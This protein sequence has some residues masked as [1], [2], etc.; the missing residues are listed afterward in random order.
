MAILSYAQM[1]AVWLNVA[2]GTQ[3]GT[4]A[5][6]SLMAAIAM[7]ESSGNANATNPYDNG[8]TQTS[9]GLWQISLGNH[10]APS[11]NWND[12]V[13][14]AQL[15]L[16]KLENPSGLDNWGTYTSGA[17]KTYLNGATTP[18][19]AGISGGSTVDAAYL[20]SASATASNCLWSIPSLG[21]VIGNTGG[22]IVGGI[23]GGITGNPSAGVS[24]LAG[25]GGYCIFSRS[26]ARGLVGAGM[27]IAGI[28]GMLSGSYMLIGLN[29]MKLAAP[30]AALAGPEGAAA[31][32]AVGTAESYTGARRRSRP[33]Q[34]AAT[35]NR[36]AASGREPA[37]QGRRRREQD[38][39]A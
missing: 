38:Q 15:A 14:N 39:A 4:N 5:Y 33:T 22:G 6:A 26:E 31:A 9:W 17:Y 29:A 13:V 3:Y 10:D 34:K 1:K 30:V 37:Y 28:A 25:G 11:P 7:A 20:T 19:G 35:E 36:R 27:L 32:G 2:Q 18:D 21:S 16:A 8:G 23:I 12:P 24:E